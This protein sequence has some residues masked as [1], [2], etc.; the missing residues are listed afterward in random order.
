[1]QAKLN[2]L[3]Y[4]TSATSRSVCVAL[5][6]VVTSTLIVCLG[7]NISW[8]GNSEMRW[9]SG[10]HVVKIFHSA[11]VAWQLPRLHLWRTWA[12]VAACSI[13]NNLCARS[14][15]YNMNW[16][17]AFIYCIL[18]QSLANLLHHSP[19]HH[20][21]WVPRSD[22]ACYQG[23]DVAV[24]NN[25]QLRWFAL[26]KFIMC[27]FVSATWSTYGCTDSHWQSVLNST[28]KTQIHIGTPFL[29]WSRPLSRMLRGEQKPQVCSTLLSK[30][31]VP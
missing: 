23:C 4:P 31:T 24:V 5:F 19:S 27:T 21:A 17:N 3:H 2:I 7:N 9:I 30:Q 18:Q 10:K 16:T 13:N 8:T 28:R 14:M 25:V 29:E 20:S 26:D 22:I 11:R 6:E 1:M 15:L 12:E